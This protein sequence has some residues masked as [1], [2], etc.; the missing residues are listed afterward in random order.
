MLNA[1][2][3]TRLWKEEAGWGLSTTRLGIAAAVVILA[4]ALSISLSY[5][6]AQT[7]PT[8]GPPK[9]F[10]QYGVVRLYASMT[11][12]GRAQITITSREAAPFYVSALTLFLTV[13]ATSNIVINTINIDSTGPIQLSASGTAASSQVVVVPSGSMYGDI[14]QSMPNYLSFLMMKDPLEN[15]AIVADGGTSGGIVITLG[16]MTGSYGSSTPLLAVATVV[17][18]SD[19]IVT[20]T[21]S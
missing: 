4:C 13:A 18:P 7:L 3:C 11:F 2:T 8:P 19:T 10:S 6:T 12:S 1:V 20:M 14:V 21:I 16:F 9:L 5:V 15:N 17:A